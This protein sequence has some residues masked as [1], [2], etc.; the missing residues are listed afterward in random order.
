MSEEKQS[1]E[2]TSKTE[3]GTKKRAIKKKKKKNQ[4][5]EKSTNKKKTSGKQEKRPIKK[6]EPQK[7]K[8]TTVSTAKPNKKKRPDEE[9]YRE[10]QPSKG[11][12]IMTLVWDILFYVFLFLIIGGA[13]FFNFNDS[14]DKSFFGYRFMTVLTNSMAPNPEKPELTDGFTS[15]AIIIIQQVNPEGLKEGDIITFYPVAGNTEAYLTHRVIKTMEELEG[16]K[17]TFIQT[18]GDANT[19]A[20]IPI[21]GSQVVGKVILAIPFI[22]S[23]LDFVRTNLVV[24]AIFIATLFG[25]FITLKYYFSMKDY[26]KIKSKKRK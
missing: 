11:K 26:E 13:V 8:K 23:F 4:L 3:F 25:F 6:K 10:V 17:G 22:G 1:V 12:K 20:D 9:A 24:V 5:S 16:E 7:T 21:K 2:S 18:Q 14:P 15:G 19:G